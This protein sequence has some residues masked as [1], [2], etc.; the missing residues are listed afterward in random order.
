MSLDFKTRM[1]HFLAI[2]GGK[3][4][5]GKTLQKIFGIS[6]WWFEHKESGMDHVS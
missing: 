3:L 1:D 4:T 2:F 6:I 5:L